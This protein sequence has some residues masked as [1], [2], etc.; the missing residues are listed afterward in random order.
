M[1]EMVVLVLYRVDCRPG[2]VHGAPV[3]MF[4]K[5]RKRWKCIRSERIGKNCAPIVTNCIGSISDGRDSHRKGELALSG[6][7]SDITEDRSTPF[8]FADLRERFCKEC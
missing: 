6:E 1:E 8:C 3:R 2:I 4:Q 7:S 5:R